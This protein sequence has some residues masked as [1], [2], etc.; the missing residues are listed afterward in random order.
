MHW[1]PFAVHEDVKPDGRGNEAER[2]PGQSGDQGCGEGRCEE[3]RE[4]DCIEARIHG[5]PAIAD[6]ADELI[7]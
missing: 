5:S 3:D 2:K 4:E 7:E 1:S 6:R